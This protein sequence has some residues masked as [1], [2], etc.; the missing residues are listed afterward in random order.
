MIGERGLLAAIAA[1]TI[2]VIV[3]VIAHRDEPAPTPAPPPPITRVAPAP[4]PAAAP[5]PAPTP[6]SPTVPT[7]SIPCAVMVDGH[8]TLELVADGG[9]AVVCWPN[10]ACADDRLEPTSRPTK[11]AP[12]AARIDG[13]RICTGTR[14]DALGPRLRA[15]A[16]GG[17]VSSTID[18]AIVVVGTQ[19]WNRTADRRMPQPRPASRPGSDGDVQRIEILGTRVLVVRMWDPGIIPPDGWWPSRG[20]IVDASGAVTAHVYVAHEQTEPAVVDLGGDRFIVTDGS[21]GFALVVQ[22]TPTWFGDLAAWDASPASGDRGGDRAVPWGQ[23][24]PVAMVALDGEPAS[25]TTTFDGAPN[26]RSQSSHVAYK[27]CDWAACH[28]GRIDINIHTDVRG[29]ETQSLYRASDHEL[30][31]CRH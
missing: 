26:G 3:Y 2:G 1:V 27:W 10:G 23:H 30:P 14:C 19:L 28:V 25:P 18:H 9:S 29:R 8:D 7:E 11:T 4:A 24:V 22:G 21:G 31:A 12:D 6:A 16:N 5:A 13:D 17:A 20:T 15:A